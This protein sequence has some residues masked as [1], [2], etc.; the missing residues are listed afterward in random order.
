MLKY[1]GN[2]VI[3]LPKIYNLM[4]DILKDFKT[5]TITDVLNTCEVY[6]SYRDLNKDLTIKSRDLQENSQVQGMIK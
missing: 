3:F 1:A 5:L 2:D 6:L 4:L